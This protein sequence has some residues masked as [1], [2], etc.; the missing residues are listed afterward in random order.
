MERKFVVFVSMIC[1][2]FLIPHTVS[3]YEGNSI[4]IEGNLS[5]VESLGEEIVSPS[6]TSTVHTSVI[7]G[8]VKTKRFVR[9]LTSSWAK[10]SSYTWSKNQTTT[11]TI[12]GDLSASAK[13]IS[14]KLGVSNSVSTSFA[15]AITIPANSSKFS[16][17]GFYSDFN[18]R[19]VK[20]WH[21]M[22]WSDPFNVTHGYHYAPTKDTYL[23]VVYQ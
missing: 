4:K 12:S 8:P 5:P 22:G 1:L 23:Q 11:S 20:V 21:T 7:S 17:L 13:V 15:V 3:A 16:K 14:G 9:Y 19:Y 18:R 2:V 6:W 10:A